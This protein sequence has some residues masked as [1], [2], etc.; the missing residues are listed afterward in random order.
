MAFKVFAAELPFLTAS[1]LFLASIPIYALYTS[2]RRNGSMGKRLNALAHSVDIKRMLHML[3]QNPQLVF[4][5]FSIFFHELGFFMISPYISLFAQRTV[6]LDMEGVGIVIATWNIGL[7][8]GFLPWA[9]VTTKMGSW[10][11]MLMHLAISSPIWILLVLSDN[12]A[13][14]GFYIFRFRSCG[15]NGPAC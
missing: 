10:R 3:K 11:M 15:S 9:W 2:R 1:M 4:Y 14:M 6:S 8:I 5:G 12:L 7:A 13:S